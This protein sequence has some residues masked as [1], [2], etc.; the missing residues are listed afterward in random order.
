MREKIEKSNVQDILELSDIQQGMLFHHLNDPNGN[1]YNVQLSLIIE[2]PLDVKN[3]K[4]AL[5]IVQS[6][7]ESLRSVFSW[8]KI[9]KPLQIVLKDCP[10][11][12]NYVDLSFQGVE[13]VEDEVQKYSA[14]DRDRRFALTELP[15][16]VTVLKISAQSFLLNITHH[17]ILYDGWSTG[18]FLKELFH[19][20]HQ[21]RN[22]I[23]P[24]VEGKPSFK[25]IRLKRKPNS[26]KTDSYW[27][28]YLKGYEITSFFPTSNMDEAGKTKKHRITSSGLEL[29]A[30]ASKH[31]VT[32][33][34]LIYAAFGILLQKY[35]NVPDVVFGL[36]VSARDPEIKGHE[37]MIGNFINTLPLR[38]TNIEEKTLLDVVRCVNDDVV[39]I[40][41]FR[42]SSYF[43]IKQ[44]LNLKPYENLFES[45][46]VI[47]NYP[48]DKQLLNGHDFSIALKSVYEN[49]GIPFVITVFFNQEL[50][51]EFVYRTSAISSENVIGLGNH[52]IS[53]IREILNDYNKKVKSLCFLS[54][55][56]KHQLLLEFNET[57]ADYPKAE[58]IH[59][60][61]KKQVERT[62]HHIA[63]RF[64]N[65]MLTYKALDE[66]SDKI[67]C[68][69]REEAN[70][71]EGDLIGILLERSEYLIPVIYGVLKAGGAYVPISLD[72]PP[73]R[74][75]AIVEDSN[76]KILI[77]G[78]SEIELS[79][80]ACQ[81]ID[82]AKVWDDIRSNRIKP[83]KGN[84]KGND[85]AYVIYTSG[86]TGKPKGVM[87]EHHSVVNRIQWMQKQYPLTEDDVLLQK[88]PVVFDVSVWELFWWSFTGASLCLLKPEGEK[89][90]REII[91]AIHDYKVTTI[92]FVPSM[93]SAFLA[94]ID[95][96]FNFGDLHSLRLVFTSGEALKADQVNSFGRSINKHCETRLINLY[97][98]TEATVDVS[99]YECSF[100]KATIAVPIGKP[101]DNTRLYVFDKWYQLLPVGV[102]GELCIAGVGLARGYLNN[103]KLTDQKFIEN[104]HAKGE[105]M[106]RTG[107][108]VRWLP[109]G[110]V[111]FLDRIDNQVKIRGFRIEL[112]EIESR[113]KD[114]DL[115]HDAVVLAKEKD[116]DKFLVAYYIA[117]REIEDSKLRHH[118]LGMLP[119]YMA[120]AYYV[121][122]DRLPLTT[123]GKLDR[124]ALPDPQIECANEY[125]PASN[126]TEVKLSKIWSEILKINKDHISI[127][128]SFFELGGHSLRATVLT[129][130]IFKEFNV[131]ISLQQIFKNQDIRSLSKLICEA[132]KSQ[133]SPIEKAELRA[134]YPLSSA[135]KRL[136]FLY[137]FDRLSTAYN[138]RVVTTL[139]GVVNKE[140]LHRTFQKLISRHEIL[141]S[142][143]W[144]VNGEPVQKVS[145][146]QV[147]FKINYFKASDAE[148]QTIVQEFVKPFD[149]QV[150][151]LMRV[152]LIRIASK[153]YILIVDMHHIIGDGASQEILVRDFIALYNGEKL[154]ELKLQ[155]K[156]FSV[157]QQEKTQ[158]KTI[159]AQRD[160]W[161]S[162]FSE[163]FEPLDLPKD[164]A[165]PLI[166]T[167]AG[168]SIDFE[169]NV[170][171]TTKLKSIAEMEG[172]TMF[173]VM[174]SIYNIFLSKL[175]NQDDIVIGVPVAGRDHP[176]LENS[177]G[178]FV[179]TLPLRNYPK[180]TF[181]FKEFLANVKSGALACFENQSY[182][183]E[184]LLEA[185]KIERN[186]SRNPLFDLMFA[187][188][189]FNESVLEIPGLTLKPIR[190]R[191]TVS[192]FDI[193]LFAFE[194]NGKILFTV[195]YSTALFKEETIQRFIA[196][197]K[198]IVLSVTEDANVKLSEIEILSERE[199]QQQRIEFNSTKADYPKD[200][201]IISLFEK[202]AERVPENVAL[203]FGENTISYC[204][205]HESSNKIAAYLQEVQHVKIGDFVGVM[206]EREEH[207]IQ[208]IFGILKVGAA[209]IPID[210]KYPA[211][212]INSIITDSGLKVLVTRGSYIDNSLKAKPALRIVDLDTDLA[213]IKTFHAK[214]LPGSKIK[215]SDLAYVIYTS[216]STGKPKGVMIEHHAVINRIVWM[217]KRYSL[218][219]KDV[220]LQKTPVTFDVS[221]WELFWWS[222]TGASLCLLQPEGEKDP[223]VIINTIKRNKVTTIHFVPSMLNGFLSFL[224][225]DFVFSDLA[226]LRQVFASG[227]ALN[228]KQVNWFG[229]TLHK[230]CG[231]SL[232][233]L[234][235]PT[236]ATVDVSYY[237]CTFGKECTL[238]PIG[239]PIDNIRLYIHGK[240]NILQPVG[241][242]GELCIGGVGVAR[243]YLNNE[244][245][246]GE[247]FID[248]PFLGD[249]IYKTGDLVRWLPD[250]NIEYLGR[251][252]HQVK[253]RG[254]R[255]E[256]GEIESQ[257]LQHAGIEEGVVLAK[258]KEGDKYLVSYYVSSQG[259]EDWELKSFLSSR[260][261]EYMVPAYF[262]KLAA[263][264]LTG[265]GK[266]DRR[267]L[268]EALIHS[269][270]V[271]VAP[272]SKEEKL[273]AEVWSKV[274]GIEKIG[275]GDNFF[276]VGGDSIKSIQ[277]SSRMRSSGYEVGVKD[278][279]THQTIQS[280]SGKLQA[281]ERVSDQSLVLG[282]VILSPIQRWFF[283][284]PI[285]D[286]NH[287]NQSVLLNF[288]G[289]ISWEVLHSMVMHLQEH[290]DALR[291]VF[292]KEE[293][294]V[295]ENKG[296]ELPVC[297][298]VFD[299]TDSLDAEGDLLMLANQLQSGIALETGPLMKVGLFQM[300]E[301]SRVLLVIHH[302]VVDGI[303]WRI[304]FEDL[305]ILYGQILKG[306]PVSL[307]AKTDSYQRWSSYLMD[308]SKSAM[309]EKAKGYWRSLSYRDVECI[310]RDNEKGSHRVEEEKS[311][312]FELEKEETKKLLRQIHTRFH[313][314]INDILLTGLVI[315]LH[316]QYGHDRVV[317]DLEGHGREG[318]GG[319]INVSRTIGWFTCIYPVVLENRGTEL[320]ETIKHIK[321]TLR[322]IPHHGL[323]Y[324]LQKYFGSMG[325]ENQERSRQI[326]FN[327]L[328]QFDSDTRGASYRIA[329]EGKGNE[330]SL[331]EEREYDWDISGMI[332]GDRL[333][334]KLV[335]SGAQYEDETVRSFMQSYKE[336]LLEIIRYCSEYDRVELTPSD[337]TYKGLAVRQ[338]DE[339][340][341]HYE[342]EDVYPLSPMQ[343]G[344]LFHALLDSDSSHYF[345]QMTLLVNSAMEV[346]L[347]EQ[348][349]NELMSRYDVL[350]TIFLHEG[351]ERSLQVVL[352]ERKINFT[353]QDLREA[354]LSGSKEEAI[355][356]YQRKDRSMKF[357]LSK[358]V[359]M[360]LSVLQTA[361]EEYVMIWSHHHIVMDGWCM[362]IIVQDFKK[363]YAAKKRGTKISLPP[364]NS[365]S[366]YIQWLEAHEKEQS[367]GYWHTYLASYNAQA[368]L[369]K[370]SSN[371]VLPYLQESHQIIL[372]K[373]QTKLLQKISR[374]YGVTLNTIL[375]CAWAIVLS[376]YNNVQ[377]VVFG[378]VVSGRPAEVEGIENMIGLFINT[379]PV[380]VKFDSTDTI[381]DLLQRV[382]GSAIESERYHYHP[383]SEI[384]SSSELGRELFD[385]IIIFENYP[386]SNQIQNTE[387]D[388]QEDYTV[389]EVRIFEQTNY[390]LTLIILPGDEIQVRAN[391]NANVYDKVILEKVL[392]HFKNTMTKIIS[393]NDTQISGIEILSEEEKNQLLYQFNDT[394]VEYA[395]DETVVSLFERQARLTPEKIAI[396]YEDKR[397]TY[398][399]LNSRSNQ[400]ARNLREKHN[401]KSDDVVG[402]MVER[403]EV[404][405]IGLLGILKSGGAY[406]PLDPAYPKERINYILR[407]SGARVLLTGPSTG[408]NFPY[409]S[410]VVDI[411]RD[412]TYDNDS[413]NLNWISTSKNLC[414]L[415]YTSGSTGK[416]KGVMI[417]HHNVVNFFTALNN[418]L[419][420]DNAD[421]FLAVTSTSFDISVLELFWTLCHGVEVVIHPSDISLSNLDRYISGEDLLI[422]F[423]LFFFSSYNN[424]EAEKYH[425]LL[426]SVKYADEQGF[427]A[428]WTPERHF[429]EFGGLYPNP[430]VVSSA[431]AMITK[432]VELR[433]GSVVSPL[434][435]VVRIAEEWSVVDNLS[436][437]RVA[438]SFA[439]GWNP[440]D[441]VLSKESYKDRHKVMYEQ[442]EVVK[443]LWKGE[444]IKRVNAFGQEVE[445]RVFPSPIQ[446]ELRIWV[447]SAGSEETFKSAGATGANV[448]THLMGQDID[449][450]AKKIKAYREA[451]IQN[452]YEE[453]AGKVTIMLH[454]Y[455]GE[456]IN[457]V[458]K[459]VEKPFIEYLKSSIGLSKVIFEEAGL[460]EEDVAEDVKEMMLKSAF[461][462]YYKTGSLIG[463]KSTCIKMIQKLK[464]IGV[465][466][467]ACLIDFGVPER[468]VME[469][470]KNLK[471][472]KDVCSRDR[473]KLHKPVTMMQSTPS[474]IKLIEEDSG[475]KKF[476]KSL[477]LLLVGGEAV[478]LSLIQRI[479]NDYPANV[480]NMYGPTET[481]VWSCM[482]EFGDS[483][484]R[485]TIGRPIANTQIYI[486]NKE[487]QLLPIGVAGDM[488]IGGEGLSKGYWKRPELTEEKF[489]PNPF[490]RVETIYNTGDIA[491]WLP[492]GNIEVVGRKDYQVKIRGHRI[493]L[494]EIEG[495]LLKHDKIKEAAVLAHEENEGGDK[496]L[497]AYIVSNE[498]MDTGELREYLAK[499]LPH[500]MI[501]SHFVR[502]EQLPITPNG[503][504]DRK[505]LPDPKLK[506]NDN[507]VAPGT[508]KEKL[509]VEVWTKILGVEGIGTTDNFFSV[510]GDSIKS[511]QII[512]RV[513]SEGYEMSIKDIFTS[514]TIKE[515]ALTLKEIKSVSDQSL[516]TGRGSLTPIQRWFFEGNIIDKHHYNQS[517]VLR[518][519]DGISEEV[520]RNI[521][522]KLQ[523]HHDA[524]RMVFRLDGDKMIQ[525]NLGNDLPVSMDVYDLKEEKDVE[526]S[527]LSICNAIQSSIDLTNGPLI[528][529]GLFYVNDETRLLIAIHHL[530]ID[531]IS[532]RI[533]FEDIET[534]Y[535]QIKKKEDLTLQLKT[536]SF[537]SW[538][539]HLAEY[540]NSRTFQKAKQY[541]NSI[542]DKQVTPIVRDN[543]QGD[544]LLKDSEKESFRLSK[545]DTLRLL[546]EVHSSF[547]T[548][549]N[550]ILLTALL[551]SI[552]KK[553]GNDTV[554]IGLEGHGRE[555]ILEGVNISR[556]VG[557]FTSI[558]HVILESKAA[559]LA[560]TIKQVKETLRAVPNKGIDYLLQKYMDSNPATE[561][562]MPLHSQLFF[563]YLGQ[564]DADTEG[565]SYT[566]EHERTGDVVSSQEAWEYDWDILGM[567]TEGQLGLSLRY[568]KKQY[569]QETIHALMSYYK[570]SLIEVIDY[571]CAYGKIT[572]TP[573][574]VTFKE[575]SIVQLD[576]LQIKYNLEDIYPLS[577]MQEALLFHSLLDSDSENYFLQM[578][579]RLKGTLD[580][581][582]VEKSANDLISRYDILR[583]VFLH[584]DYERAVQ[585]VLKHRAIDFKYEDVRN[586]CE[587]ESKEDVIRSYEFQDRSKKF[588]LS[589]DVL[590]RL[591]VLQTEKDEFE[592]I[593]SYH[594]V[595]M[596]GWCIGII[597]QDFKKIYAGN[598]GRGEIALPPIKPYSNYIA[599]LEAQ[600]KE[601]S[602]E[603][604]RNY[605]GSYEQLTTLP[606]KEI[607]S[608]GSL[609]YNH[610]VQKILINTS[611]TKL[612][613]KISR[614]NGVT[615]NTILQVIWG[616]LLAKYNSVND[617]VF[618]SVVSGRPAE[619]EGVERMVGLF[620]NTIPVRVKYG[621]QCT[622]SDLL[623]RVQRNA[624]EGEQ[625]HYSSLSEIQ[626]LSDLG[627]GLLDHILAFENY[628]IAD[629]IKSSP[630]AKSSQEDYTVTDVHVFER[631]NYDLSLLIIPGDE[632]E[633]RIHYDS[634]KY[635]DET[636]NNVSVHLNE[637]IGQI[638]TNS[639][640][641]VS[642]IEVIPEV[643]RQQLLYEFNNTTVNYP[644]E[645]TIISLFEEQ[646]IKTPEKVALVFGDEKVTYKQLA[647]LAG[648]IAQRIIE[649]IPHGN[650]KVGLLFN[651][652]V[653]MIAGM[654]GVLK[655]GCTYVPLSPEVSSARNRFILCDCGASLLVTVKEM[656]AKS[657]EKDFLID[658]GKTVFIEEC[659]SQYEEVLNMEN[660]NSP[661][662]AIYVIYTSGTSG[663]PRGV[664]VKHKGVVNYTTWRILNYNLG[665]S[666]V[667]LQ[668]FPYYFDGYCCNLYPSL[669]SGGTLVIIP[670]ENKLE[671]EYIVDVMR[672]EKVTNSL[673]TPGMYEIVLN[674]IKDQ[675]SLP[676]LRLI[677]LGGDK[678]GAALL[679]QSEN[680][681]P[682][683]LLGNEYGPTETSIAAT[684]YK[685]LHSDN[686]SIIGKPISNTSIYI[687]GID[688][689]L[690]P[691]GM[692]GEL[693]IAGEGV[694]KGYINS[695]NLTREKFIDNPFVQ[696]EK[697]YKTGDLARWLPDGNVEF[698]GR[699]DN[700]VK[701]RGFRIELEEIEFQLSKHE[702]IKEAIVIAKDNEEVKRLVAY[703]VS[704]LEIEAS[705]LRAFLG[706]MLPDYMVPLYYV[707]LDALPLTPNGK[708]D[709]KA[710][711]DPEIKTGNG[712]TVVPSNEVEEKLAEIWSHVLKLDKRLID[713]NRSFFELGGHSLKATV[714]VNQIHK[715]F[716]VEVPVR[717]IFYK[718]SI[719]G[720][721]DYLITV[722]QIK[723]EVE[724]TNTIEIAL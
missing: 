677:E 70:V 72:Y 706:Q 489:I 291:M 590:I 623:K 426:E 413:S 99:Y 702:A 484:K 200:E 347:I 282:K 129:N 116:G 521:F 684:Y 276:S 467:I 457:E 599:W 256:L 267:A 280:L 656:F 554:M 402:I 47:E 469:G 14:E 474:F 671:A 562:K 232:I 596:D 652:S 327:Y 335:Y 329:A 130:K 415:I 580:I 275:I 124:N 114:Y 408:E 185:L 167:Y 82:L 119:D 83:T 698:L 427:Q 198:K 544:N 620:I 299:L 213:S 56:E 632:I 9:S 381:G 691:R 396:I 6:K 528:K 627:G 464:E 564:F 647:L 166:N 69:F 112:G 131:E 417:T 631:T 655:S 703:Y 194:N 294:L 218:S 555:E 310:E 701:I 334:M 246:T 290:H 89:Q 97:G 420:I 1:L 312:L 650:E 578:T 12:F 177:I 361:E 51:I 67:A 611:K 355:E 125:G 160:F 252:D 344:M 491:R 266:L 666:D 499:C 264:P 459:L 583:T 625:H 642:A 172:A 118:L 643:E 617:V 244:I 173:M 680:I 600:E 605:L 387:P 98:P 86:S 170:E 186:T 320:S 503:K 92:H 32:K 13:I 236:E 705:E 497:V 27:K 88:T 262:V 78:N 526:S 100:E 7:N 699:I 254:Y 77:K 453:N 606:K 52:L 465:D 202:Q 468:H 204:Q 565:N 11:D 493:E 137:E 534:L 614:D 558:Y 260:L 251:I 144:L 272:R 26:E 226:S 388:G 228:P 146:R 183:Y 73:D 669:L 222:F 369:P 4:D 358:D 628:P 44:Y 432:Q 494:E 230:N 346:K 456:N 519:K 383:L 79:G 197:F 101:I 571:C 575:V 325:L 517:V 589:N 550:D 375:Q 2:G 411:D 633:I 162:Q 425:L 34:S 37:N 722:K 250:G 683:V 403:S 286:K 488:Y 513:R 480:Y 159:S 440:N 374:Q 43:D 208:F 241:V 133:Y 473:K 324:L 487:L 174:L 579:Y 33:A 136:Y 339:L 352:K 553:Y 63:L 311:E 510:G 273:L 709:R 635:E 48:L 357:N 719:E 518:F 378:S 18:I 66:I 692:K 567:L 297:V 10:I 75:K 50:E 585:I 430:S 42:H 436:K 549:I 681:L 148:A 452:G 645:D 341:R 227:E 195:E 479:K 188:Q 398:Q 217:Q 279:F 235:G 104:P 314:Q 40:N 343:E 156:D 74:I 370:L 220:L 431:L 444:S 597:I 64:D 615:L 84:V 93:L 237:E 462:R 400:L 385:H 3:L 397:L 108:L 714:L 561:Y 485:V 548:Q 490:N 58:T 664:E 384:Q 323:D 155:Y 292:R 24:D 662:Q 492:D 653:E 181:H 500:Y 505:A 193:T 308:Y 507:Y 221:V 587:T 205:L 560:E 212:R 39:G 610:A 629:Q 345:E 317:I 60:L 301:G 676:D 362:G 486:L 16:R 95:E 682:Y 296:V 134:Y 409:S 716:K 470:L 111:E 199:E 619:I 543:P 455:I 203:R 708:L 163:K 718:Q 574:D 674:K 451:R 454:T 495:G 184:E 274:L 695:Q 382:Q 157:W 284:G 223:G 621:K 529:L 533:L 29:A 215:G 651:S 379:I 667:T 178:M 609:P 654:L 624:I 537:L 675:E 512:S 603:F 498:V 419:P 502:L 380:R 35:N 429:H 103:E 504:L 386:I 535:Q 55:K 366:R 306:E 551:L 90:P 433:S 283:E 377:D 247:K 527:L 445:L 253:I 721:A 584:H 696:D 449:E 332:L 670:D 724:D 304:L 216:G 414:Y 581:A 481:T 693:C 686:P 626:S 509:L 713:V 720:L 115:I 663:K 367:S 392:V 389:S 694:A 23:S 630:N 356:L 450:L 110:N 393:H 281:L 542:L 557:W 336:S 668:L 128:K 68:Y 634:N 401:I 142:S 270:D 372:D 607:P 363:I 428:V 91:R 678:T 85:L 638:I 326:C 407:D 649:K 577:P 168:S 405:I 45:I 123:N 190:T 572:L 121:R 437:G 511:I 506:V 657:V 471:E 153:K 641:L 105:K 482:H 8:Q 598:T 263:L 17:H 351:Y 289:G 661:E 154:P 545:Q 522:E 333:E 238:V 54:E 175:T 135:Q 307:P 319:G 591:A 710:S 421:S 20:Y 201:T 94:E 688:N 644:H 15:L 540:A 707:R 673:M 71:K 442:I 259:V 530:V 659:Q 106:Y 566:T 242:P 478:P 525:E 278:I 5:D 463:T 640:V 531:G 138:G 412:T 658:E 147:D 508:R 552:K 582:A 601:A 305:E 277:I 376:R 439:S 723:S 446:K 261:P 569:D 151:S 318:L 704:D 458:E 81:V 639:K 612:L 330:V 21:L 214:Q 140:R 19:C 466:E 697:M 180:D 22:N 231:T 28:E 46:V 113:L 209:Y 660:G 516:V 520:V 187:Y 546:T 268:P 219:D 373:E 353:Y 364:V 368:T 234:Y 315:S 524:L 448:L 717:E 127:N 196:Y 179:N 149:L 365:Y 418:K 395:E 573:S 399:E 539:G 460:K 536:D 685:G 637:I 59:S 248:D 36:T 559:C 107:D 322:G 547:N 302:L 404:M 102:P 586:K 422:D 331:A 475:S 593:W 665:P 207:L 337:L 532:W 672:K 182:P 447:T 563:N 514:L 616:I 303:S 588:D 229:R 145:Q 712:Y 298:E 57:N 313:T 538:S 570:E 501:P 441:F 568:S 269:G 161:I 96:D 700:Q 390:D 328:G 443:K 189:N 316:K 541:W 287:F 191:H 61:F 245:L 239:K 604:W 65:E 224:G 348:S 225:D 233:N 592:F 169:I 76:L 164:F 416:P 62:P 690:L 41:Q 109:D 25:E 295:G 126:E 594:H 171:E 206:L 371:E 342:I 715:Y 711:P 391:Y 608:G 679:K 477:K 360:R 689:N 300:K 176:D 461:R 349:M 265:N 249:R 122:L 350:R 523:E 340:Q 338:L 483:I 646:V 515:L 117:E 132:E 622:V 423:S 472:L 288:T 271:Y 496:Y 49:T 293:E 687:L 165:R 595:L 406:L 309:F 38:L 438:L 424:K 53:I 618:G 394:K 152:G 210:S 30:F 258:E 636:I 139:E 158:Q 31:K 285:K 141:R 556:T 476:L 87:I 257:L 243:G 240:G 143:F 211:E 354:C 410:D 613:H 602:I 120:P 150:A 576:N 434:H 80:L 359:L 648:K 255:I 435:D 321:E 192:K